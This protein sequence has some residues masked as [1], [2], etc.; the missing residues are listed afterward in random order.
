MLT[1]IVAL[2]LSSTAVLMLVLLFRFENAHHIRFFRRTRERFDFSLLKIRHKIFVSFRVVRRDVT[3]QVI[4]YFLHTFLEGTLALLTRMEK[5]VKRLIRQNRTRAHRSEHERI[6]TNKLEEIAL[7]KMAV[8][9]SEK[10][11][12]ERKEQSLNGDH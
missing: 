3:R 2:G 12:R 9:L 7:H 8:A 10:E 6:T 5:R 11:K 4:R 1:P